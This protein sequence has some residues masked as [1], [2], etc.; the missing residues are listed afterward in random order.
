MQSS[1]SLSDL[2]FLFLPL[3]LPETVEGVWTFHILRQWCREAL[4]WSMQFCQFF[5]LQPSHWPQPVFRHKNPPSTGTSNYMAHTYPLRHLSL[6]PFFSDL[7]SYTVACWMWLY[8]N[9]RTSLKDLQCPK[10]CLKK[11]RLRV[12]SLGTCVFPSPLTSACKA[13]SQV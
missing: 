4:L 7:I 2:F 5:W 13:P 9:F 11:P 12:P 8:S 1:K 10:R 6:A 3:S